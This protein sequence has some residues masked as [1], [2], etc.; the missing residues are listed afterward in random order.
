M[1]GRCRDRR[2]SGEESYSAILQEKGTD[3][4]KKIIVTTTMKRTGTWCY[5]SI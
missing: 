3:I 4:N 2:F 5:E 1:P